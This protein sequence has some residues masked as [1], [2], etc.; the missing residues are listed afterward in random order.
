ME[1]KGPDHQFSRLSAESRPTLDVALFVGD[2][3]DAITV[4][5]RASLLKADC[6]VTVFGFARDRYRVEGARHESTVP[7]GTIADRQYVSRIVKLCRA[8]VLVVRNKRIFRAADRLYARNLDMA[9]LALAARFLLRTNASL[10]YEVLDIAP[11]LQ[12][13]GI[14]SRVARSL[15]Q[16][17]LNACDELV[18]SSPGFLKGYF[19]AVQ[20]YSGRCWL[21]ENKLS[22]H[23]VEGH[24]TSRSESA[25]KKPVSQPW[26]LGWFG[27][28]RSEES[29]RTLVSAAELLAGELLVDIWGIFKAI[30]RDRAIEI[31][32]ESMYVN[33]HGAYA[34]ATDLPNLY[35]SVD[36]MWCGDV[37]T[38]NEFNDRLLLPNRLY[39]AAYFAVPL[40]AVR[41]NETACRI[42]ESKLGWVLPD[43]S[44]ESIVSFF[45]S[46]NESD[47][48]TK[49]GDML[50]HPE[51]RFV[52]SDEIEA[53]VYRWNATLNP[54][55][56]SA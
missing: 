29:L 28:L 26:R 50:A 23:Q 45:K 14:K 3:D 7:L 46:L 54:S 21:I 34:A 19:S 10:T 41:G 35:G 44:A 12:G 15:E 56:A 47:Y 16:Y 36:F 18:V 48:S 40:I 52:E 32:N 9:L 49:V 13:S 42:D 37:G 4:R 30:P 51:E 20:N 22:P 17:V 25:I 53:L 2:T 33:Y 38:I 27:T 55:A 5:R 24:E 39:E 6:S 31:I 43:A 1:G 11:I 8:L